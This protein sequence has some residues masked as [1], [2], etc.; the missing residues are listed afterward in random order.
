MPDI[1]KRDFE[2]RYNAC[3]T[4]FGLKIVAG[5]LI[6]SMLGG[7]FMHGYRRWPTCIGAGLGLG[8]A[9]SNCENSLNSFLLSMDPKICLIK[10]QP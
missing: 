9:Y 4:D 2:E 6:G 3:F 7:F 1:D 8:M 10:R 5:M